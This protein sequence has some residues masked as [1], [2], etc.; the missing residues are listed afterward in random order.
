VKPERQLLVIY[1]A[2]RGIIVTGYQFSELP[3]TGIPSEARWL[4]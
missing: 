3:E 1:S 4:K 2:D